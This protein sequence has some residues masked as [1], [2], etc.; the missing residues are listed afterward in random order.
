M[1]GVPKPKEGAY[2]DG[3]LKN[4]LE[5]PMME[6]VR[7]TESQVAAVTDLAR[8]Y[9]FLSGNKDYPDVYLT[10]TKI[11]KS[12]HET[13][14]EAYEVTSELKQVRQWLH[15]NI[16]SVSVTCMTAAVIPSG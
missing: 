3:W 14:G 8:A 10:L 16:P 11:L 9:Q 6:R 15:D 12:L 2:W 4:I 1:P 13:V 5:T 7:A